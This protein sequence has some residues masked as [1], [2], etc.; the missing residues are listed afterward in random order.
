LQIEQLAALSGAVCES[1][2]D[3][4]EWEYNQNSAL[5]ESLVEQYENIYGCKP[6]IEATHGGL[7]CGIFT[8]KLPGVDM[9]SLG[10]DIFGA[11]SP[12]EHFSI[13]SVKR[14]WDFLTRVIVNI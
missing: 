5:R 4:P 14:V 13:S 6:K 11:H 9:I 3:Y 7:E 8:R 12:D 1:G 2:G 10:P